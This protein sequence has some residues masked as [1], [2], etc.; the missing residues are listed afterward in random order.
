MKP[1]EQQIT[2]R[3]WEKL[4]PDTC[5]VLRGRFFQGSELAVAERLTANGLIGLT[6]DCEAVH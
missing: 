3:E 4:T 1:L 5:E 2:L 6:T